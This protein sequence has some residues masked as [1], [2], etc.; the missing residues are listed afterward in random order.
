V[1]NSLVDRARVRR[2]GVRWD[3]L[4]DDLESQLAHELSADDLDIRAEEERLR[5]AR[6]GLRDRL[7][8]INAAGG[9][10]DERMLRLILADGSRVCV[11][12][13]SFGRDWLSGE[14]AAPSGRWSPCV[15]PIGA[16]S[17]VSLTRVQVE[18]SLD[19]CASPDGA[20]PVGP[21][22]LSERLGIS[23]VLRDLCRRRS[24]VELAL[25]GGAAGSTRVHGTIDR[26]GRDHVDLAVHD[27][28]S[29]RRERDVTEIRVVPLSQV[30]LVR[31]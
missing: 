24:A 9:T 6:L 1:D 26:V 3:N 13:S 4:F 8:A 22:L 11:V 7:L 28:T 30:A 16:I 5:L 20:S 29:A 18:W 25:I 17:S 23:L 19:A 27:A 2:C 15:V 31:L 14:L 12:P 21:S 10:F